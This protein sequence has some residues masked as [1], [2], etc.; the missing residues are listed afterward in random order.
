M[1]SNI[2]SENEPCRDESTKSDS[3]NEKQ[4][5]EEKKDD[6]GRFE[7]NICLDAANDAV[8]TMCGHL[9]CWVCLSYWMDSRPS[10]K[11]CPVCKA[12]ISEDK[13]IPIYGRGGNKVDPRSKKVPP[14]PRGQ[15]TEE[16]A[17][18]FGIGFYPISFV[19]SLFNTQ[20]NSNEN[21]NNREDTREY[22]QEQMLSN[23]SFYIAVL[24]LLWLF[25]F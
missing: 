15:R 18:Q 25:F 19:A 10:K 17:N 16:P 9:Y 2:T 5:N 14:R 23:G 7:C 22:Q 1:E 13:I 21:R 20:T 6:N 4:D 3:N 11:C 12:S 8:V 24:F